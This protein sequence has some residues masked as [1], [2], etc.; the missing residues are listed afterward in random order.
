[1]QSRRPEGAATSMTLGDE[2]RREMDVMMAALTESLPAIVGSIDTRAALPADAADVLADFREPLPPTGCGAMESIERLID[3]NER[4]GGNAVGP[5]SF[6]FVI[7][8]STPAALAADMLANAYEAI[9][10]T[11][12]LTPVGV[13][14]EI[15]A[16]DWLKEMFGLPASWPAVMVTGATMANFVCLAAGR[17][18]W[19]EQHGVDVSETGLAGLPQ[20]PVL[21]SGFVHAATLKCIATQ[22]VGRGN[23]RQFCRDDFGRLDIDAMAKAL[24]E[25]DG[26]PAIVVVNAGEV[27]AEDFAAYGAFR[28][29]CR[30]SRFRYR[31]RSQVAQC[32]LRFGLRIRSRL[33]TDGACLSVLGRLSAKRK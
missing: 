10:Y 27:N 20:M 19:G 30:K 11:W 29:R 21:T 32:A 12:V 3:L 15:Q 25:L 6:H 31:R 1:M 18:W 33:R 16:L 2:F 23:V 9:P 26:Q 5:K 13:E 28:G 4:A 24:I 14:M 17:Q 8:G 22:G 7:G